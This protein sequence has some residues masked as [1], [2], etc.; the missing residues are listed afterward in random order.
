MVAEVL[1]TKED[2][3]QGLNLV[4]AEWERCSVPRSGNERSGQERGNEIIST[5]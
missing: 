1:Y 5:V 2:I 3:Q 4:T